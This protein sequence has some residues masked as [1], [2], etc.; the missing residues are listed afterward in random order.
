M[1]RSGTAI[2]PEAQQQGSLTIDLFAPGM[3][4]LHRVGLAGLAMTLDALRA[5]PAADRL[6]TL[7]SWEV[8]ER[9]VQL[10]WEGDGRDF[11]AALFHDSF[12]L[13]NDGLIWFSALG[14]P[15][16]HLGDAVVLHN[17]MLGTFLQHT[18]SRRSSGKV[19]ASLSVEVDDT[20][21]VFRYLRLASYAHQR[22][23]FQ[24]SRPQQIA[25]WLYPGGVV[26]HV[27]ATAATS[28]SEEA[29][30]ALALLFA[31]V[32]AIFFQVHR[33]TAK[34]RPQYCLV[35][36]EVVDLLEYA[37]LRRR[38]LRGGVTRSQV[39]G[40]AE[41]AIRVLAEVE[42]AYGSLR[43]IATRECE[44]VAFGIVPWSAQQKTR[45]DRFTVTGVRSEALA[46]YRA[47]AAVLQPRVITGKPDPKTGE[48]ASWWVA[49]QVPDLVAQNAI[50]GTPWWLGFADLWNRIREALSRDQRRWALNDERG[51]LQTMVS[52]PRIMPSGAEARL[53]GACHEALRRRFGALGE[54]ATRQGL[55]FSRLAGQEYERVRISFARCKNAVMLRQT[56]TDFWSRGGSQADLREAWLDILP[57]LTTRWQEARDLALLALASYRPQSS[58]EATAVGSN[59]PGTDEGGGS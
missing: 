12:R 3:T 32:G 15:L 8:T 2:R 47:A 50:N 49:P 51:G 40:P 48:A 27:R 38:F 42:A 5:D 24:P 45:V 34:T 10:V 54:R 43:R 58:D 4:A 9:N 6:Q 28:L 19:Q 26:R 21:H 22:V 23:E 36:P 44:V 39:A 13:T 11:F 41:A 37:A 29:D 18:K 31:P 20:S 30:R 1:S 33:R 52:D 55:D 35:L 53:V 56:L 14:E 46:A 16:E 25:G 7:G 57:L 17:A 59:E